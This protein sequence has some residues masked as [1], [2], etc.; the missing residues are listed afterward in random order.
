M[1]SP[2]IDF[3]QKQLSKVSGLGWPPSVWL[4]IICLL[5]LLVHLPLLWGD[6][7]NYDDG[8]QIT[9][10]SGVNKGDLSEMKEMLTTNYEYKNSNPMY[11]SFLLNWYLTPDSYAGFAVFNLIWLMLIVV[12]FYR[13]SRLFFY[14]SKWRLWSTLIFSL[15]CINGDVV[16]WMSARCHYGGMPFFLGAFICWERYLTAITFQKRIGWYLFAVVLAGYAVLNK[17]TFLAFVPVL[18]LYEIYAAR[19]LTI[20]AVADKVIPFLIVVG[21]VL[22][23]GKVADNAT[24]N[25]DRQSRTE[26]IVEKMPEVSS[27][28]SQYYA[29]AIIPGPT[30]MIAGR[31]L[32]AISGFLETPV[33]SELYMYNL[34]PAANIAF[35]LLLALGAVTVWRTFGERLPMFS[36]LCIGISVAPI[37][38]FIPYGIDFG[39][40][41]LWISTAMVSLAI[42]ALLRLWHVHS[43]GLGRWVAVVLLAGYAGWHGVQCFSQCM[44]FNTTSHYFE[45]CIKHFPEAQLCAFKLGRSYDLTHPEKAALAFWKRQQIMRRQGWEQFTDG[46]PLPGALKNAGQHEKASLFYERARVWNKLN[47]K[48]RKRAQKHMREHP[49]SKEAREKFVQERSPFGW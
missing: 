34:M 25:F 43:R 1:L 13:F 32:P 26:Q 46:L 2:L 4:T 31:D 41:Y 7:T 37:I 18:V 28:L 16:G 47:R 38:G 10:F 20:L 11:L 19:R 33:K 9:Q 44:R 48:N 30:S 14:S 5:A 8:K 15:H 29:S 21:V 12:V 22:I 45:E 36:F 27:K 3:A 24:R 35:L 23:P 40:R 49:I 42:V 39:F 17:T 6:F